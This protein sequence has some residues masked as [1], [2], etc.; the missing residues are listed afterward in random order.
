M[1]KM[2][3]AIFRQPAGFYWLA[4]A[5]MLERAFFFTIRDTT[6]YLAAGYSAVEYQALGAQILS[7]S[8]PG[9][10][11]GGFLWDFILPRS[12]RLLWSAVIGVLGAV[13]LALAD[14][15]GNVPAF[16]GGIATIFFAVITFQPGLYARVAS[17]FDASSAGKAIFAFVLLPWAANLGG[18][19]A[20]GIIIFFSKNGI[21]SALLV[22]A[23]IMGGAAWTA[24]TAR[25]KVVQATINSGSDN[26]S[27][28]I[29]W[30]WLV[31]IL[32]AATIV[33]F[34]DLLLTDVLIASQKSFASD[35]HFLGG[36]ALLMILTP[37][38]IYFLL[39][40]GGPTDILL[41]G[42]R[43]GLCGVCAATIGTVL[44]FV[45]DGRPELLAAFGF[46]GLAKVCAWALDE[47]FLVA[48][49]IVAPARYR[50]TFYGV[51]RLIRGGVIPVLPGSLGRELTDDLVAL[52]P[53]VMFAV[54][55]LV[56]RE[57]RRKQLTRAVS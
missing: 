25:T 31:G 35:L 3:L 49:M 55:F 1:K 41:L 10:V 15:T 48:G 12:D 30:R 56:L 13:L 19:V 2:S 6:P 47:S 52:I 38:L 34:T 11:A 17:L 26:E 8:V 16:Y 22:A 14:L 39:A 23:V 20:P 27:K 43:L 9:L 45:L 51:Y 28:T 21:A 42:Q 32:L 4:L 40:M 18:L 36:T 54:I 33:N 44:F 5:L 57:V 37:V 46:G 53:P 24:R 29:H 7:W 50:A